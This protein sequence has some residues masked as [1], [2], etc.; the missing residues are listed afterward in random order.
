MGK[1]EEAKR[2]A[3]NRF[4]FRLPP[5]LKKKGGLND[6]VKIMNLKRTGCHLLVPHKCNCKAVMHFY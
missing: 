4:L 6:D 5:N 1:E 2:R 3:S